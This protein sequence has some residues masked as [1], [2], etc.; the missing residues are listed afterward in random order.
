MEKRIPKEKEQLLNPIV[1]RFNFTSQNRV[2]T[3][4]EL[5]LSKEFKN[6]EEWEDFYYK[7]GKERQKKMNEVKTDKE[8]TKLKREHGRTEE[9]LEEIGKEL[10]EK[11]KKFK[12]ITEE[13]CKNC[14]KQYVVDNTW[15]GI[16]ERE[17]NTVEELKEQGIENIK[18]TSG[19]VDT[20]FAVDFE[21]EINDKKVGLQIKPPTYLAHNKE[22]VR[23]QNKEKQEKYSGK[24]FTVMSEKDGTIIN[25]EIIQEIKEEIRRLSEV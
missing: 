12:E 8:K 17:K 21:I 18:K 23:K 11:V 19:E 14:I 25:Q 5:I 6:K 15:E 16:M 20:T 22:D 10:Y 9:E 24:V 7:S 3:T 13:D 2:G 4:T 1:G